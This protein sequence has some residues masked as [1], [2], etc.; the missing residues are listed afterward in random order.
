MPS[1]VGVHLK[2]TV[3]EIRC[4]YYLNSKVITM[5]NNS[6]ITINRDISLLVIT[7]P[8]FILIVQ[9]GKHLIYFKRIQYNYN[10]QMYEK[11]Q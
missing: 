10:K 7:S 11:Q 4:F 1:L 9:K 3:V 2:S 5:K 8:P 6:N